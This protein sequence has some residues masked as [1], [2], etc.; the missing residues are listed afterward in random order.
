MS[1]GVGCVTLALYSPTTLLKSIDGFCEETPM[2]GLTMTGGG[3]STL[4]GDIDASE[5]PKSSLVNF[6]TSSGLG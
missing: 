5:S 6:G 2:M 3:A 4:F 1:G